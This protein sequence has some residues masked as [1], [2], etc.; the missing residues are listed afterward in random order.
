MGR[1]KRQTSQAETEAT[2]H[3][4]NSEL[5]RALH[6]S[7]FAYLTR[8]VADPDQIGL[9]ISY[10][11]LEQRLRARAY[12]QAVLAGRRASRD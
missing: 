9:T 1:H 6:R 5:N 11:E 8:P 4:R 12:R 2:R 10:G 7:V 3:Q